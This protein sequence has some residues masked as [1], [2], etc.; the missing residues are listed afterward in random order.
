[1]ETLQIKKTDELGLNPERR[2]MSIKRTM[3]MALPILILMVSLLGCKKD[4]PEKISGTETEQLRADMRQLWSEHMEWTYATVDAF[5]HDGNSLEA[6]LNR[7]LLNQQ[8]IGSSIVPFFGQEAGDHLADLLTTHITDAVPVLT[9]AQEGNDADLEEALD[10]WYRNAQEIGDYYASL[11]PE[12]WEQPILRDMWKTHITQTVTY[13]V[14]L[15]QNE[16]DEAVS[17][18][19]QAYD[20][21]VQMGDIMTEGIIEQ[22]PDKF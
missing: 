13:S 14:D 7:L 9:A 17:D 22:H 20:H 15:L 18:Y 21:M 8:H 16:F 12:H 11:N 19:Q 1:M 2:A 4:T 3:M 5:F 10:E 6:K